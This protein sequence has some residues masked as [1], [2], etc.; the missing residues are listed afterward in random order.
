M[1]PAPDHTRDNTHAQRPGTNPQDGKR[2]AI[3]PD[4]K[5]HEGATENQVSPTVPPRGSNFDDE[6]KQG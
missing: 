1:N 2:P 4:N 6:P 5:E 3:Q